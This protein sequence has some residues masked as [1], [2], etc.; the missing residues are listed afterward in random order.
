MALTFDEMW[1]RITELLKKRNIA[2]S[3]LFERRHELS[4]TERKLLNDIVN[5]SDDEICRLDEILQ[6]Y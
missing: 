1:N 5:L 3:E 6:G 4:K 2:Y